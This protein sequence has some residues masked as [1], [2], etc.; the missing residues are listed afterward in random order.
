MNKLLLAKPLAPGDTIGIVAPAGQIADKNRFESGI[1]ILAEMGFSA[2]FPR[3]QWPGDGYFSDTDT[4]RALEFNTLWKDPEVKAIIAARGGYGS[5]RMAK[6][7]NLDLIQSNPKLFIGFSDVTLLHSYIN[8]RAEI[9]TLHGP[10]V[11]SLTDCTQGALK[12]LYNCLRGKWNRQIF[13]QNIEVLRMGS[14]VKGTLIGGNLTT[15]VSTLGTAFDYDWQ[16]KILLLEDTNEPLY[17][18]DRMLTQL[19]FAGKFDQICAIVLGDFSSS[20]HDDAISKLRH[21]EFIWKRVLELTQ[22]SSPPVL[23][24]VPFGHYP[25]NYTFPMGAI[26]ELHSH[27]PELSFQGQ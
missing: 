12:S 21:H 20:H 17:R 2:K 25:G 4:N 10:V 19:Y 3:N 9:I 6:D 13:T 1:K 26:G 5:M 11:T 22:H 23:G 24:N 15:L 18:I 16:G 7:I 14:P 27:K 8:N